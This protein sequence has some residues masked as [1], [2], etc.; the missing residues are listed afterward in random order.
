[1]YQLS[2]IVKNIMPGLTERGKIKIGRKGA[3]RSKGDK[4]WQQ[5]EKL[6]HFIVTKL[7]RG[8]DNNFVIDA[9]IHKLLGGEKPKRIP[10]QLLYNDLSLNFQCRYTC[11]YGKTLF[12]TGDGENARQATDKKGSVKEVA[13][14]CYRQDPTFAGDEGKSAG[15]G[16]C[17]INGV[18]SCVIQ[19]ADSVGGV[20]KFRTTGWNSTVGI[21]SSLS[22]IKTL[23]GGHLAGLPLVTTI[24]P[25]VATNPISGESVTIQVVGIEFAGSMADLQKTTLSLATQNAAF[26]ARLASVETEAQKMLSVDADII[27]NAGDIVDEFF[28][29][30]PETPQLTAP[31]IQPEPEQTKSKRTTKP[32][33]AEVIET[34][35]TETGLVTETPAPVLEQEPEPLPPIAEPDNNDLPELF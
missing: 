4:T 19:G 10:I 18:L 29:E 12:C 33:P 1:M 21:L 26:F 7:E 31:E 25:K 16:K 28:P 35:N 2:S 34:V 20:W 27:D 11:Y 6:D 15:T 8:I 23:T 17:K 32:K 22:F 3:Q 13:C 5:P 9:D 14:T 30:Q 24:Q